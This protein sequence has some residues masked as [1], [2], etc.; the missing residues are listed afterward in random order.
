MLGFSQRRRN[1][2]AYA[3]T[4]EYRRGHR[5]DSKRFYVLPAPILI[6]VLIRRASIFPSRTKTS[7]P[8]F[9]HAVT[10]VVRDTAPNSLNPRRRVVQPLT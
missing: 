6:G 10:A 4:M 1:A 7:Q 8:I 9:D 5:P 3:E 2:T